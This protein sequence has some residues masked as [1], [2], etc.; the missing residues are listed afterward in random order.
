MA[1]NKMP[2]A[3]SGH[4]RPTKFVG[5]RGVGSG[6]PAR[7][8][9]VFGLVGRNAEGQVM[10]RHEEVNATREEN[11]VICAT[12]RGCRGQN[13]VHRGRQRIWS[14]TGAH[15]CPC[16]SPFHVHN[17]LK[18]VGSRSIYH[19]VLL[20]GEYW[21]KNLLNAVVVTFNVITG[22]NVVFEMNRWG[23]RHRVGGMW[24]AIATVTTDG[25]HAET[26]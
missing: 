4:R 12:T 16:V 18:R 17:A 9:V 5:R 2:R 3:E 10:Q 24:N 6:P 7:N 14:G 11:L 22:I 21:G 26:T 15:V 13:L 23:W 1:V 20:C 8:R 25:T 19:P